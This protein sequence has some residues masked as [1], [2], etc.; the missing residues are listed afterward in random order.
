MT[1]FH[2]TERYGLSRYADN[3]HPSYAG[4]SKFDP[5]DCDDV[6]VYCI[7]M[8]GDDV[9][10]AN[11]PTDLKGSFIRASLVVCGCGYGDADIAR[12]WLNGSGGE[13]EPFLAYRVDN[14]AWTSWRRL[15]FVSD[16]PD[17]SALTSRIAVLESQVSA[18]AA[19]ATPVV[20]VLTAAELD[21][22]RSGDYDGVRVGMPARSMESEESHH[23]QSQQ[24]PSL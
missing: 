5:N 2:H 14:G 7:A 9:N 20:T 16:I 19:A 10:V 13:G 15:A 1:A 22:R 4:D 17:V 24:N 12:L 3:D 6:G 18:L 21:A 23:E 11:I 8:V